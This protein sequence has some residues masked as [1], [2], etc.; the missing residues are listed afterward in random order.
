MW[1]YFFLGFPKFQKGLLREHVLHVISLAPGGCQ[2]CHTSSQVQ[3]DWFRWP[4]WAYLRFW[5]RPPFVSSEIGCQ[6]NS[7]VER[8]TNLY[9]FNKPER[10]LSSI[11]ANPTR[12]ELGWYGMDHGCLIGLISLLCQVHVRFWLVGL[13]EMKSE[14]FKIIEHRKWDL[15]LFIELSC[16]QK[17]NR[18]FN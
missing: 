8:F 2:E 12:T 4:C 18:F 5:V 14:K 7:G 11:L 16:T 6:N 10:F 3:S 1:N 15:V 13:M 9:N 17:W